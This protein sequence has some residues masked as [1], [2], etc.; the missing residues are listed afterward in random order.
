MN[1]F[2]KEMEARIKANAGDER[3]KS[4]ARTLLLSSIAAKYSYNFTWLSRPVIQY[5]QDMV[6]M[7]ELI[8]Q[9]KPDLI[10]ETGIAHGGSLILSASML[11]LLDYCEAVATG[12]MLDPRATRRRVLGIDID[13]RPHNR[14]AIEGHPMAHRIDMIQGSSIAPGI[15]AQVHGIAKGYARILVCLDSNH[16]HEHV[17]AELEAYAPLV[18]RDSYCVVFDTVVEDLPDEMFPDRPWGKG[19][20]PKTAVREYLRRIEKEG[21]E[22]MDGSLLGFEIDKMIEGKLLITVAPDGY[23]KRTA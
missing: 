7:Q 18:S 20:N 16:T 21:R 19:D 14:A 23:L 9:V 12:K 15:I 17:L 2:P 11:A 5:P 6:A 1:S 3:L 4:D 8:W 13:I 10:V 22:A